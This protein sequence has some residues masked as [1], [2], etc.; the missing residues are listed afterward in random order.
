MKPIRL[1]I[2]EDEVLI[3]EGLKS[4]A[5]SMDST[6]VAAEVEHRDDLRGQLMEHRPD[7]VILDY[8][9]PNFRMEDVEMVYRL[10]PEAKVLAITS[11]TDRP[12][13]EQVLRY[14]LNGH[15]LK[16]CDRAEITSAIE[17]LS[18]GEKFFCGK[19]LDTLNDESE[20]AASCAPLNLSNRELEIIRMVAEGLTN[21][22]IAEK[23]ILSAHTV[24]THRKNIMNK[25]GLNNTAGIVMYAVKENIIS[26]NKFLFSNS[27]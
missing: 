17:S 22:E 11:T 3:R 6:K 21:K 20:K 15:I 10:L 23:L 25:L 5:E 7:L 13:L 18:R 19:V 4:L 9:S 1:L 27:N 26:P 8:T 24:M 14:G 16:C 12:V 2:A